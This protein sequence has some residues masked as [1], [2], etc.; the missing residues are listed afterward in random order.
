MRLNFQ[1]SR[2]LSI[3]I[4]IF[5]HPPLAE[6]LKKLLTLEIRW[7]FTVMKMYIYGRADLWR[8]MFNVLLGFE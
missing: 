6:I 4:L 5:S 2:I 3:Y 1:F 7:C 8:E